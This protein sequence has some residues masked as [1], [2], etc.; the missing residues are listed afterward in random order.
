MSIIP[1]K[2][3]ALF[4]VILWET[5]EDREED[6]QSFPPAEYGR[7]FF[8]PDIK[9]SPLSSISV[10][11]GSASSQLLEEKT[12]H[13]L[14]NCRSGS[15]SYSIIVSSHAV[16]YFWQYHHWGDRKKHGPSAAPS[17][18]AV[19]MTAQTELLEEALHQPPPLRAVTQDD[20]SAKGFRS[21]ISK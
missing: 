9:R 3:T 17:L 7:A 6:K 15:P 21:L 13:T 1:H 11:S 2:A 12:C 4:P 10:S 19:P 20:G 18:W 5:E 8:K 16:C 14:G